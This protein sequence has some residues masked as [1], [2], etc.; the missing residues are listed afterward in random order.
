MGQVLG[1]AA[2]GQ[3][4]WGRRCV[5][6]GAAAPALLVL[7]VWEGPSDLSEP[8]CLQDKEA[9]LALRLTASHSITFLILLTVKYT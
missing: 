2:V 8:R 1:E 4:R 6:L 9:L 7:L 3:R 5:K